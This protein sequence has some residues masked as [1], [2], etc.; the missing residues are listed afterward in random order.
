[1]SQDGP[2]HNPE[3]KSPVQFPP[4]RWT[5]VDRA[6][7]TDGPLQPAALAELARLYSPALR[8]HLLQTLGLDEHRADDLLQGF[9]TNKVLEQRLIGHADPKRGRFRT[10]ILAALDRYVI[11]EHRRNTARKR[12]PRGKLLDIDDHL[13]TPAPQGAPGGRS[14]AFDL[15]W[16]R[17]VLGEVLS[18][19]QSHCLETDRA[20][21]W[22]VFDARYLKPATENVEPEPHESIAQRLKLQSPQQA[23]NLLVTAKR[24]FTRVFKSVVSRYASSPAEVRSEVADLWR[25]FSS[26]GR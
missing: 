16:A 26:A 3:G 24:M 4:T 7:Q 19:M 20:D 14:D 8:A 1:M 23:G 21:L 6:G 18:S 13:E 15:A 17:E 22:E 12:A 2:R 5:L 10:F 11:D 9:L 25:I